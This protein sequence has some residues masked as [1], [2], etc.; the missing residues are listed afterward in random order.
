MKQIMLVVILA[1]AT[2]TFARLGDTQK[3][4]G[5]AN[6]DFKYVG[7][8]PGNEPNTMVRQY[9]G[10]GTVARIVFG[11]D[12]KVIMEG[13]SDL[14]GKF[15]ESSL[16]PVAKSY[17]Y[18]FSALE[19]ISLSAP[20]KALALHRDF[21]FSPDHKFC[22]GI[23]DVVMN[24]SKIV[25][26]MTVAGEQVAPTLYQ[27][28]TEKRS[29]E[30]AK[31]SATMNLLKFFLLLLFQGLVFK[32]IYPLLI[33]PLMGLV[34]LA[35]RKDPGKLN[36]WAYLVMAI[37]FAGNAYVLW[38]WAAYIAH[39]SHSWSAAPEVTQHWLYFVIG[40]FGCV[41]PLASMA[42]GETNIGSAIHFCLTSI[43]FI[44]FCI[45]P[46]AAT[47]LYGWLPALFGQ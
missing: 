4:F 39:L 23:G 2:S 21:W 34:M 31:T 45:W 14:S 28:S 25:S 38:G 33:G 47:T 29:D 9:A 43:A 41:G 32:W 20:W 13:Y 8:S 12:G 26:T 5:Q 36:A 19:K 30:P 15:P 1:A 16:V 37:V 3:E 35:F 22:I 44:V 6:P 42:A 18:D 11:A 17:G 46:V 27:N 10:D 7:E 24:D 40:F